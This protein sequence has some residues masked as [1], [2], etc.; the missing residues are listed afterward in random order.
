MVGLL[1]VSFVFYFL[2]RVGAERREVFVCLLMETIGKILAG[3]QIFPL[4]SI[5]NV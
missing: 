1:C 5:L 3:I 2:S 4:D